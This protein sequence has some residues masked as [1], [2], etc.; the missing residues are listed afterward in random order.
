MKKNLL[1]IIVCCTAIM[2]LSCKP[3]SREKV[4]W[5]NPLY[6]SNNDYWHQRIPIDIQ[7]N[8]GRVLL[9]D[10]VRLIIGSARGQLPIEG[11]MAESIRLVDATGAEYVHNLSDVEGKIIE[12]G[13]VPENSLLLIPVECKA[14][15]STTYYIYFDNPSAWAMGDYYTTVKKPNDS[16]TIRILRKEKAPISEKGKTEN[17]PETGDW[18][19]RAPMKIYNFPGKKDANNLVCVDIECL[20]RRLHSETNDNT[21]IMVTSSGDPIPDFRIGNFIFYNEDIPS[22]SKVINYIYFGSGATAVRNEPGV[23]SGVSINYY[24]FENA[25]LSGWKGD[26]ESG[27]IRISGDSKGGKGSIQLELL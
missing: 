14:D 25:G 1:F 9:G 19:S 11:I 7:N 27:K 24:D 6:L 8:T 12:R 22:N 2:V 10:P 17:W 13:P 26:L 18:L 21:N 5:H 15:T 4:Q 16:V 20:Q 3:T 23:L